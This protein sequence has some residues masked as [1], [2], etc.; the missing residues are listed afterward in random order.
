MAV[1]ISSFQ[2]SGFQLLFR[3]GLGF[4]TLQRVHRRF[5]I[6]IH[7]FQR[8]AAATERIGVK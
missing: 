6:A 8:L 1:F 3:G 7:L 2:F 4:Q 5:G